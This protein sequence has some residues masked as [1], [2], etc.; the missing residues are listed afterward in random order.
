MAE[1][2][3]T[4]V[5]EGRVNTGPAVVLDERAKDPYLTFRQRQAYLEEIDA[6]KARV[7]AEQQ[8]NA[9]K[10][11]DDAMKWNPKETWEPFA[12]QIYNEAN[13]VNDFKYQLMQGG[14][15]AR[16]PRVRAEISRRQNDVEAMG[17]RALEYK[18]PTRKPTGLL[19]PIRKITSLTVLRPRRH[20]EICFGM[21]QQG[22]PGPSTRST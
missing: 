18:M 4:P 8:E 17:R 7:K 20:C 22:R 19:T 21:K 13:K 10:A 9:Y 16:D 2:S 3:I 5:P 12:Q 15:N 11:W 1:Q 14:V 6:M